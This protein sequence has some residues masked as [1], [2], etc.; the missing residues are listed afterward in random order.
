MRRSWLYGYEFTALFL[1]LGSS[2]LEVFLLPAS[3]HP[4]FQSETPNFPHFILRSRKHS[5]FPL[6]YLGCIL[7]ICF[8]FPLSS[9]DTFFFFPYVLFSAVYHQGCPKV[10]V[11]KFFLIFLLVYSFQYVPTSRLITLKLLS[12]Q[13]GQ[14]TFVYSLLA[15]LLYIYHLET[16]S[17]TPIISFL[18]LI[19]PSPQA[20]SLPPSL[21]P[22]RSFVIA[23]KTKSTVSS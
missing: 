22:H 17:E 20:L 3:P 14:P 2:L 1:F 12:D 21:L 16:S 19:A 15:S 6:R 13:V 10:M 23:Y 18:P 5:S 7:D 4:Y 8:S 9:R 11:F